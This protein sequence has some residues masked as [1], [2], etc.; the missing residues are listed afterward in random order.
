MTSTCQQVQLQIAGFVD[1]ELDPAQAQ[2]VSRHLQ[3]CPGCAAA[4]ND[5]QSIKSLVREKSPAF[6]APSHLRAAIRHRL[7]R[8]PA[9]FKFWANV[10]QLFELQP[11]PAIATVVALMFLSSLA[12]YFTYSRRASPAGEGATFVAGRLEGEVVCI[13]CDLLDLL[14]T[15]YV[16]DATH[17]VGLRCPDGRLWSILRSEKSE[18]LSSQMHRRVRVVGNLSEKTHYLEIR[19]FSLI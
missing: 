13:D 10:R 1:R 12:T 7:E 8:E 16:H 15:A 19:E 11:L 3:D 17:R 14:K 9:V 6:A 5:Q 4:A 18:A 2:S